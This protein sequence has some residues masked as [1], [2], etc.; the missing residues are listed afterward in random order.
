MKRLIVLLF[1]LSCSS[2]VCWSQQQTNPNVVNSLIQVQVRHPGG[3]RARE[4]AMVTLESENS[5]LIGQTQ[6][7]PMGKASFHVNLMGVYVVTV[8]EAGYDTASQRV[9]LTMTPTAYVLIDLKPRP[10]SEATQ[11]AAPSGTTSAELASVPENARKE[12]EE[13]Q[14]LAQEKH[15]SSGSIKHFKKAIDEYKDFPQA[16]LMLGL[17]YLDQKKYPEAQSALEKSVK[18][19]PASAPAYFALGAAQNQQK[20][21]ADAEKTLNKGLQLSPDTVEGHYELGKALYSEGKWQ[22]AEPHIT[23][24]TTTKPDMAAAHVLMGNIFLHKNDPQDAVKEF[25][26]YL[27][28]DPTGPMAEPTKAAVAKLEKRMASQK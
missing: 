25:Q 19:A 22:E 16:Y 15:D 20:N 9:D 7:D 8:K 21:F 18:L 4:G 3:I 6:T 17:A 12:Y 5:G 10:G 23:K 2:I 27:K 13:G 28:L 24:V 26:E 1:A 14:K 11:A